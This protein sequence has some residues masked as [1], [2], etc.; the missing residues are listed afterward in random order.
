MGA[1]VAAVAV[2]AAGAALGAA[3][4]AAVAAGAYASS[5]SSSPQAATA[6]VSSAIAAITAGIRYIRIASR[7]S[8]SIG[9]LSE[10]ET[11]VWP[12]PINKRG[13]LVRSRQYPPTD[14]Y[15]L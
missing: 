4:A 14:K 7:I 8:T 5:S 11:N 13:P 3:V 10:G 1:A 12:R 9:C 6:R 15:A 2:A